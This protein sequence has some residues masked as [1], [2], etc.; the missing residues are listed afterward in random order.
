MVYNLIYYIYIT[1]NDY[2]SYNLKLLSHYASIFNGEIFIVI[3]RDRFSNDSITLPKFKKEPT[4]ISVRNNVTLGETEHFL[5]VVKN[6]LKDTDSYTFYAHAKGVSRPTTFALNNWITSLYYYNL[7]PQYLPT[8]TT[9]N[10]P[11]FRGA[12]LKNAPCP[13][14]ID[15]PYHFS[16]TF[17]WFNTKIVKE[18]TEHIDTKNITKY[19]VESFP[20]RIETDTNKIKYT[21]YKEDNNFNLYN[22]DVWRGILRKT[23]DI[24]YRKFLKNSTASHRL[25]VLT[26]VTDNYDEVKIDPLNNEA[27]DHIIIT[28]DENIKLIN[29]DLWHIIKIEKSDDP[30]KQ[31]RRYKILAHQYLKD[32]YDYYLYVDPNYNIT[33]R[34]DTFLRTLNLKTNKWCVKSHPY[35]KNI[36]DEGE[37][38]IQFG[39]DKADTVN[40][41]IKEYG[42]GIRNLYE[43]GI[44]VR[45]LHDEKINNMCEDWYEEVLKHS[46]RDQLSLPYIFH[47]YKYFPT[48][49]FKDANLTN[50]FL[51]N[52]HIR[53]KIL[54]EGADHNYR[55][56]VW[57]FTPA[58]EDKN[59][60]RAYN[61]HCEIVPNDDDWI[62]IRDG[63]TAF[64]YPFFQQQ[65]CDIIREHG[66]SYDLISCMTNRL[67]L[68]HQ[69]H[70]NTIS[71]NFD[72]KHHTN[73]A[74]KLAETDYT[75]VKN[76]KMYTAGLFMLFKKS[77]WL[78]NGK[79]AEGLT[80]V[81]NKNI[82][83]DA[84][85]SQRILKWGRIGIAKGIYLLHLYRIHQDSP[86]TY[87][88][89]L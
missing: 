23:N 49:V 38:I 33:P 39:K 80:T 22:D 36:Y 68:K 29:R 37:K 14:F 25:A 73:I 79:F 4:V 30:K 89:L 3:A 66:E 50:I 70:N 28:D 67:G 46:Y 35:R 15:Q 69:L 61:E 75:T 26:V 13:P 56:K 2:L 11:V 52:K 59:L 21:F 44:F 87:K 62:C 18:R 74:F 76:T 5:E 40:K 83:I 51:Y 48:K 60:G 24:N 10:A 27:Y 57:H 9:D 55:P 63:D 71:N 20:A 77:T 34:L 7:E 19:F 53:G 1:K 54:P 78:K 42:S 84:D 8:T 82:F 65:I 17:F 43:N 88:H 58:D 64:L 6:L 12:I 72:L 47:K 45:Y 32:N 86:R 31:S 16:G 81:N 41:Q 85:F